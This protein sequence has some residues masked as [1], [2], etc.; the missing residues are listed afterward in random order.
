VREYL[1]AADTFF[2]AH[3][4]RTGRWLALLRPPNGPMVRPTLHLLDLADGRTHD[5][6]GDDA[7]YGWHCSFG[8][9]DRW[10]TYASAGGLTRRAVP[11]LT[12]EGEPLRGGLPMAADAGGRVLAYTERRP[13]DRRAERLG[14]WGVGDLRP[15]G[16][17]PLTG[18]VRPLKVAVS[19]GGAVLAAGLYP[20]ESDD[21]EVRCYDV[22]TGRELLRVGDADLLALSPDGRTVVTHSARKTD[23][24]L[25][26][27]VAAWDVATGRERTRFRVPR[28]ADWGYADAPRASPDGR[29][30]A[31]RVWVRPAVAAPDWVTRQGWPWPLPSEGPGLALYDVGTGAALGVAA[32]RLD[33]SAWSPDGSLLATLDEYGTHVRVWDIPPR[34][35]LTWF[36]PLAALL[37]LPV[38]WVA[39]RRARRLRRE[40]A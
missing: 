21:G 38:A 34:K 19:D 3:P 40:A 9:E 12:P 1:T 33:E 14:V 10:L 7:R 16:G 20:P 22:G 6:P 13:E 8:P 39:R 28:P 24:A 29:T 37:A 18:G 32:G 17:I 36:V 5:A 26:L 2:E 31:Q 15:I 35:R 4:S 30:V 25:P 23:P 27:T 11:G